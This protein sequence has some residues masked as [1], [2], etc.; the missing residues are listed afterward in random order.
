MTTT[1]EA[2]A[3]TFE[4]IAIAITL[5]AIAIRLEAITVTSC[6]DYGNRHKTPDSLPSAPLDNKECSLQ[7]VG[8]GTLATSWCRK[9]PSKRT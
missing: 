7:N 4:A 2:I 3:I 1:L 6:C 8:V 9:M 5:E